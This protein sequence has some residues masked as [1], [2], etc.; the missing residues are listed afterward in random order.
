MRLSSQYGSKER[1][2]EQGDAPVKQSR[3]KRRPAPRTTESGWHTMHLGIDTA[4]YQAL[5]RHAVRFR[6]KMNDMVRMILGEWLDAQG[7]GE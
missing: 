2:H 5:F 7:K 6:L 1:Q 4:D 3:P